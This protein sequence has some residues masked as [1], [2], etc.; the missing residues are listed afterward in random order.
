MSV[1]KKELG[2]GNGIIIALTLLS[3]LLLFMV[4]GVFTWL[5]LR[6]R[7]GAKETSDGGRTLEQTTKELDAKP[8]GARALPEPVPSVTEHP[9]RTFEPVYHERKAE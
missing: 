7:G 4:E 1:M 9:T 2:F 5:I 8:Q 6:R 3:F